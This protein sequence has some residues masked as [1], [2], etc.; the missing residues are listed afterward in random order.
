MADLQPTH[1]PGLRA[2]DIHGR[3]APDAGPDVSV[4]IA[5][6]N[7]AASVE[8]AIASVLD[9]GVTDLECI[10]VDDGSTDAT[11][12]IVA[13][14]AERDPR[15]LLVRSPA[16][17]GVSAARNRA[18]DAA[19]GRWLVFLDADDLL[20]RGAID[21]LVGAAERSGAL[22]A[23][24]QR[25]VTDGTRTWTSGFYD[26]PDVTTPGPKSLVRNHGLLY[27]VS[28][29]GKAFDRSTTAGLRFEGRVLGDQPWTIRAML[30]AGD[31]IEVVGDVVYE[32]WRPPAE[33]ARTITSRSRASAGVAADAAAV[34]ARSLTAVAGEIRATIP[35]EAAGHSVLAAYVERQ[36]RLDLARSLRGILG[37]NDPELPMVFDA[38]RSFLEVVPR[39]IL[40]ASTAVVTE[41]LTPP[42]RV[43]PLLPPGAKAAWE[44]MAEPV[45]AVSP[46]LG[47]RL[48]RERRS[49]VRLA[50][51]TSRRRLRRVAGR[52]LPSR[53]GR[54]GPDRR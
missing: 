50:W 47:P 1:D 6:W 8:R 34:A 13:G 27:Y 11:A 22:V 36:V 2:G 9:Q 4:L 5:A 39:D 18:L 29:T 21:V 3:Q 14:I 52:F 20:T 12:E 35:D 31:R 54:Q 41:L 48:R 53:D 10:V 37:K 25:I 19:H 16:N 51:E 23:I 30:R 45:L 26:N 49:R 46:D 7:A 33:G 32:W 28:M 44:R 17:E 43:W 42:L 38:F 15:V 24:G 40:Q